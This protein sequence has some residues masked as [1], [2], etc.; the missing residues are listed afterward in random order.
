MSSFTGRWFAGLRFDDRASRFHSISSTREC[1][2]PR[3]GN[4]FRRGCPGAAGAFFKRTAAASPDDNRAGAG[5]VSHVR[6]AARQ[7]GGPRPGPPSGCTAGVAEDRLDQ[8]RRVL[9]SRPQGVARQLGTAGAQSIVSPVQERSA[10]PI[11]RGLAQPRDVGPILS[12]RSRKSCS[13]SR[14]VSSRSAMPVLKR[15][16]SLADASGPGRSAVPARRPSISAR[17]AARNP[18]RRRSETTGRSPRRSRK[19]R[20]E[21]H[22]R[23]AERVA[24]GHRAGELTRLEEPVDG[25]SPPARPPLAETGPPRSSITTDALAAR[26]MESSAANAAAWADRCPG[27]ITSSW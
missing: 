5:P 1:T 6:T 18:S 8:A 16:V 26:P 21:G 22:R 3:L 13:S 23:A 25:P 24:G 20:R 27:S 14:A 10:Q 12:D 15:W 2:R 4:Q 7:V 19:R 11:V 17:T 9:Q